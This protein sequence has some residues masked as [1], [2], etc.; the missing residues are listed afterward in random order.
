MGRV[1]YGADAI[2]D[3]I[4]LREYIAHHNPAAALRVAQRIIQS[5]SW[6]EDHPRIGKMR[7]VDGTRELLTPKLD[8]FKAAQAAASSPFAK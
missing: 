4:A 7:R 2:A 1:R 5:V 6:L 3:L 8:K